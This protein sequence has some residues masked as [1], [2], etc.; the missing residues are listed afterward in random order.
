MAM[1]LS[2]DFLQRRAANFR[3]MTPVQF[4]RRAADV[5]PDR[6]AV[7][8]GDIKYTWREHERRCRMLASALKRNGVGNGDII[9]ILCPNT[10]AM[11]EAHFGV[12]MAGAI[13]NT[14]NTRLDAAAIA[15]ILDHSETKVLIVDRQWSEVAK[16]ALSRMKIRPFVIDIDDPYAEGGELIGNLDYE[17][18]LK[19]GD[20]TEDVVWPADEF[21]A[22][23]LNYTSGTTGN[24]KGALYHH[25]G[26]YLNTLSQIVH[27]QLSSDSV[28]LWTL[29]MF[30]VNGWCFSWGVA[31]IGGT[32]VCLR[33]VL[34]AEIFEA[35]DRYGVTHMC[36]APTVL[37]MLIEGAAKTGITLS[38]PVAIMTA[39][40]APPAPILKA[41][42]ELGFMVR[43]V[44]GMTEV[45][46]VA[47]LCDWHRDWNSMPPEQRSKQM[48]RQ[49]VR[50]V[51]TDDMIVADPTTLEPL[52]HDGTTIG[53][54]LFRGNNGMKGYLKN[55]TATDEAFAGGWY[56]T[57]D[58]A[59]THPD[60]YIEIK[61]RSKDIIISGGENISS[62]EIEEV[63]FQ[64]PSVSYAA[65]VAVK[66][67]RW[68]ETPC[69]FI[70]LKEGHEG[71]V[72]TDEMLEFCRARLA[73]F[74]LP[75]KFIFGPIER[76]ST[77]KVQKFKL[78]DKAQS[79]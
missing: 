22:I 17:E 59:V 48:A 50:T 65:A 31:A 27:H 4:L 15:F 39:G 42:E 79:A 64:H 38:Q 13:L 36:G 58:L 29:P 69:V 8:H 46:G 43:H 61:D 47:A 57:G 9:A 54:I 63:V 24:P 1:D 45:H 11:L 72:T 78:R 74:K 26:C 25:R 2:A 6:T 18:F 12:P 10:P 44:Y 66:D 68:G 70:E 5:F 75:R 23:T 71:K 21:D 49:G 7:I 60:G 35:I 41:T 28:Y 3:P 73:K 20:S 30:H 77:G 16:A 55:P 40:A 76:T 56:R 62:I 53:E 51:V 52:P 32:H 19:G 37:G 14:L 33:R 67:D 34:P